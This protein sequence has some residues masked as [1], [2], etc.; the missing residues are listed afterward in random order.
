MTFS[1]LKKRQNK[2]LTVRYIDKSTS[3]QLVDVLIYLMHHIDIY[4]LLIRNLSSCSPSLL[5]CLIYTDAPS[6]QKINAS[7]DHAGLLAS[8]AAITGHGYEGS[9]H[10]PAALISLTSVRYPFGAGWLRDALGPGNKS[11]P[12]HGFDPVTT[13]MPVEHAA[14]P[15]PRL[16]VCKTYCIDITYKGACFV[17]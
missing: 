5:S 7:T 6:I 15:P 3:N 11:L 14:P 12:S 8:D 17:Q 2:M 13:R 4:Y 16:N 9:T 10:Y 1:G